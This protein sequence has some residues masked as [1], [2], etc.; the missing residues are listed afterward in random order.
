MSR[1]II[2]CIEDED[3]VR[4]AVVRDLEV[5]EPTFLVEMAEDADDA[6]QVF[7]RLLRRGVEEIVFAERVC[8]FDHWYANFG[9]YAAPVRV[10]RP[11][12]YVYGPARVVPVHPR[13]YYRPPVRYGYR[14][15][16]WY[17]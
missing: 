8:G 7:E 9:F 16:G 1:L 3:E 13:Y 12:V 2:L 15:R 10:Y 6:R 14:V 11:R 17:W 5:F 4:D